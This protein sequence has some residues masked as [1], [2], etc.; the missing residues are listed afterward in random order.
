MDVVGGPAVRRVGK[1]RL[2]QPLGGLGQGLLLLQS[3]VQHGGKLRPGHRIVGT[4]GVLL[5][6]ELH[7]QLLQTGN[8][9]PAPV[10]GHVVI[11]GLVLQQCKAV[12]QQGGAVGVA[13]SVVGGLH[14]HADDAPAVLHGGGAEAVARGGD[15]TR[16][17]AVRPLIG[18]VQAG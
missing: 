10:V 6:V 17:E 14:H 16:L 15:G 11:G 13:G 5:G 2:L 4:E 9:L 18:V 8:I 1:V 3:G 7:P 12:V